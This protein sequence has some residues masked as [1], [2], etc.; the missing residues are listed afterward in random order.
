MLNVVPFLSG[1]WFFSVER[2]SEIE[3]DNTKDEY[4]IIDEQDKHQISED[5]YFGY[6]RIRQA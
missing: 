5:L 1:V 4:L 3:D 6:Q 2:E